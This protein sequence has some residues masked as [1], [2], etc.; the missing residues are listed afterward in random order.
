MAR[1]WNRSMVAVGVARTAG[2]AG[3]GGGVGGAAVEGGIGEEKESE[4][5]VRDG[6]EQAGIQA[7]SIPISELG[8]YTSAKRMPGY[9]SWIK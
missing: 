5:V 4:E 1:M 9:T 7:S 2:A 8:W 3:G 6:S